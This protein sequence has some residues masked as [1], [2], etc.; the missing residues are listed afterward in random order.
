MAVEVCAPNILRNMFISGAN[1]LNSKR[2]YVD[3]LNVFPVPDGDTGTNMNLTITSAVNELL[4]ANEKDKKEVLRAIS[5]GSLRGAR[6]NSGVILS[7]I[8]RGFTRSLEKSEEMDV[9]AFAVAFDKSAKTAYKAV[10]KPKEGTIL[11][12]IKEIGEHIC[13]LVL[14][15]E[16]VL[17]D[18]E[19]FEIKDIEELFKNVVSKG[20]ET[21]AKTPD[22]LPVLKQAGVVD[23]GGQGLMYIFEGMYDCLKN[24]GKIMEYAVENE[25]SNA[26]NTADIVETED[27]TFS[28]CTEFIVNVDDDKD[29]E[30]EAIH[31][32]DYLSTI[33]DSIV[34]V[35][36]DGIIK[37]HVHTNHPGQAIEKAL[38]YGV[39]TNLKIDN[40]REEHKHRLVDDA[41]VKESH[42]KELELASSE[43]KKQYGFVVVSAGA[44]LSEIFRS[45]G[46]DIIV[47]GGQTM[48]PSTEDLLNAVEKVNAENVFILPNNKNIILAANQAKDIVEDKNIIVLE[49]KFIT[50]GVVAMV[51][52]DEE[53]EVKD[54]VNRM[55][56]ALSFVKSGQVTYAIRDTVI[57]E[58]EIKEGDILGLHNGHIS[59]V[60]KSVEQNTINLLENMIDDESELVSLYYGEGVEKDDVEELLNKLEEK[61]DEIDFEVHFGGQPLYYYF[62]SVE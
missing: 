39:L 3:E 31:L 60:D 53:A 13:E 52:F 11:T 12:V 22:L 6:G 50:D 61:Y 23:S 20:N 51:E 1:K 49:T 42:D 40:M 56:E 9:G 30:I 25:S 57:E 38:T 59:N 45:L 41:E 2:S 35:G 46:A 10:M 43:E 14:I 26:F 7:Q 58:H 4:K 8:L 29:C 32:R 18:G 21:L 55:K 33:G 54:N 24:N 28:Y 62:I 36:Y 15:D 19:V 34:A 37:I 48:N 5:S 44:G 17:I 27:I 16:Q 47:E